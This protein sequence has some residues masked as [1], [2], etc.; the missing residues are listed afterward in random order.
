MVMV[1]A[2]LHGHWVVLCAVAGPKLEVPGYGCIPR[3]SVLKSNE[4]SH[5]QRHV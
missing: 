1:R 3:W 2:L 4:P 5:Q